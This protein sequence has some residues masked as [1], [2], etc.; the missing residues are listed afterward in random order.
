MRS[1]STFFYLRRVIFASPRSEYRPRRFSLDKLV[2]RS[3]S[4]NGLLVSRDR[5]SRSSLSLSL[6]LPVTSE[7]HGSS[8]YVGWQMPIAADAPARTDQSILPSSLIRVL[9][10]DCYIVRAVRRSIGST[11]KTEASNDQRTEQTRGERIVFGELSFQF[12]RS[13]A[14][15]WR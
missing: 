14:R 6:S 10:T 13:V 1:A 12:S 9:I 15:G 2:A 7:Y 8:R 5:S 3:T 4:R 11:K